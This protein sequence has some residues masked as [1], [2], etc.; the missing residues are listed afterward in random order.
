M[1]KLSR[2][3]FLPLLGF[4][5]PAGPQNAAPQDQTGHY[6]DQVYAAKK[7]IFSL[8]PTALLVDA[9]SGRRPGTALDIGMGQGR[10]AIFL[11]QRG[12][13]VAGFDPSPEGVRQAQEQA[14][15]LGI[16]LR[17]IVAK[18]EGFDL[19]SSRWDLIVMTYVR[20]LRAGDAERLSRALR[21]GGMFV[22]EN[23]NVGA[24]NELLRS[25]L[26]FRIVRFEDVDTE[27]DWHPTRKQRVERLIA[28][29]S[30]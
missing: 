3:L 4:V 6:W 21:P 15:K 10:N 26:G 11:A 13:D 8:K 22:Y 12:W 28:E 30:R 29:N 1:Q 25:F 9:V 17:A 18:E 2:R 5:A 20:R 24:Q 27:S 16:R 23:N 19:F 7:P 14:Q